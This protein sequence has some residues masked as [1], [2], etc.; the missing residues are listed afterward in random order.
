MCKSGIWSVCSCDDNL[1]VTTYG[2]FTSEEDARE[3][4]AYLGVDERVRH[5]RMCRLVRPSRQDPR[6][7]HS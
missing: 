4:C 2:K 7:G 6:L 1:N 5:A 3:F